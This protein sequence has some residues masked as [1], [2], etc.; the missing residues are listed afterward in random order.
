VRKRLQD[1]FGMNPNEANEAVREAKLIF[2][3]TDLVKL[4]P[5]IHSGDELAINLTWEH[6]LRRATA[7]LLATR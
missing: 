1:A 6:H 7:V 3:N 2:M 4:I 5:N